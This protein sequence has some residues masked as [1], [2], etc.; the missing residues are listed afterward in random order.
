M[1]P[2]N[3]TNIH[4]ASFILI[5]IPGLE[6]VQHW[7]SIPFCCMYLLAL[8]GN[9]IV[10]YVIKAEQSLREPMFFFLSMLSITDMILS[11][12]ALPK[13]LGIFWFNLREISFN[14][15]LVQMFFIHSF[16]AMESGFFLAMAFDRY[17]AI[18]NPLRHSTILTNPTIAKIGIIVVC[19][20]VIFFSPH[21]FL[22][23]SLPYCQTNVISHTYCEFM[24][25]MKIACAER[26][27]SKVY[28]LTVALMI[29]AFDLLST[30][31]S[32]FFILWTVLSLP[33]KEASRKAFSTCSSHICVIL[34]FYTT[35]IF[36]FLTHR[37]GHNVPPE[38]HITMANIYLLVPPT[39]NPIIYGVRTKKIR[40]R[41]VKVFYHIYQ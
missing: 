35:A 1:S 15:C 28:S 11:T 7:I 22:V 2:L 20:G 5:G 25:L 36:T 18:C 24:A 3:S 27:T 23:K 29:A 13:M 40:Q 31:A 30:A 26:Y 41:A 9:F 21:V 39:L 38:V 6:S 16:T 4:P 32:Y 37:F 33:S 19:R 14:A 17:V 12:S 10:L 8:L 34:V